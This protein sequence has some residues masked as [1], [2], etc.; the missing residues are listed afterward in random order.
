MVELHIWII[1]EHMQWNDAN[2]SNTGTG[3][4]QEPHKWISKACITKSMCALLNNNYYS[5]D[6]FVSILLLMCAKSF[7][8]A[9]YWLPYVA[10]VVRAWFDMPI[11]FSSSYNQEKLS[12]CMPQWSMSL[13]DS[14]LLHTSVATKLE[15]EDMFREEFCVDDDIMCLK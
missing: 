4:D 14:I 15:D 10:C 13:V 12:C 11:P 5:R 6:Y 8:W 3:T 9:I 7:N 2:G 1:N